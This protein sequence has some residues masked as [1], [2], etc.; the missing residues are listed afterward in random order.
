MTVLK[1][2]FVMRNVLAVSLNLLLTQIHL[3]GV[4]SLVMY[5][6][7]D[8]DFAEFWLLMAR[9]SLWPCRLVVLK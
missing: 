8:Q 5:T 1:I 9:A 7:R 4:G 2:W 3:N 6:R